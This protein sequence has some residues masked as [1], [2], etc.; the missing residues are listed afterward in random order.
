[1][2][3]RER[4]STTAP[5]NC[6]HIHCWVTVL[7]TDI[8]GKC[9]SSQAFEG[10]ELGPWPGNASVAAD[11]RNVA[12]QSSDQVQLPWSYLNTE[13]GIGRWGVGG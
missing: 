6:G 9:C 10:E 4:E 3:E 1:M 7:Y 11:L 8:D 5:G 13:R 2:R 12:Q